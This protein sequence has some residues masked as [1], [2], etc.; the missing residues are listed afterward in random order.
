MPDLQIINENPF[1]RMRRRR[2]SSMLGLREPPVLPMD[3]L[4]LLGIEI[5][6][7]GEEIEEVKVVEKPQTRR[8][9]EQDGFDFNGFMTKKGKDTKFVMKIDKHNENVKINEKEK[10]KRRKRNGKND[11]ESLDSFIRD[12]EVADEAEEEKKQAGFMDEKLRMKNK[13]N[14]VNLYWSKKSIQIP[15]VFRLARLIDDDVKNL[16]E[17]QDY[18][19]K[20]VLVQ[21]GSD[22]NKSNGSVSGYSELREPIN[23]AVSFTHR[24]SFNLV[25][26]LPEDIMNFLK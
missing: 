10:A 25:L 9:R 3:Q 12:E 26:G 16:L 2:R 24:R 13:M 15:N 7:E 11:D 18:S 6:K 22:K 20:P 17:F 19:R 4:D 23:D 8:R 5:E 14:K 21:G 1:D